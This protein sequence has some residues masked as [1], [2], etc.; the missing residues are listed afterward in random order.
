MFGLDNP[1]GINVMPAITP[2]NNSV[3]LWFTEGG[4]GLSAS[5]PGQEW[6]NQI[7]AELLGVLKEAGITPDKSK[8]NQLAVAIKSIVANG[9]TLTDRTGNSSKMA[10]SQKLVTEVNE[11]ANSRMEKN[12]NGAD[13]PNKP[14]FVK[15]IGAL[16]TTGGVLTG[17]LFVSGVSADIEAKGWVGATKLYDRFDHGGWSR[18]YSEAF[19]PSAAVV[20]AYS[21]KEANDRYALKKSHETFSCGGV[22]VEATHD[23][24]GLKLKN[25]NGYYVQ[26]SATPHENPVMLTVYYRDGANKTQYYASLRKKS[27]E[28]ALLSD[29]ADNASIGINQSWRDVRSQRT[30]G[31]QYTNTAGRP[32]AVFVN[33][34]K[35]EK[36]NVAL[37]IGAS[38]NGVEVAYN[39]SGYD[40]PL[41]ILSVFFIV[42][43]GANYEVDAYLASEGNFIES[44]SELR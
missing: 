24:A 9:I 17:K 11:N 44:W 25:A 42:P 7:Q 34:K 35:R 40:G 26:F 19:P 12:Q 28:I 36:Y 38:V 41:S 14:E 37:G 6:F 2:T 18:A 13:I 23:W 29:V 16:P 22:D 1:S 8:L 15:N 30:G 4:A 27:G 43:V 39:W 33:T 32:I 21:M 31:R 5:Y 3:P 20:G 10:A